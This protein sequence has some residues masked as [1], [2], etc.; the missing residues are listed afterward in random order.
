MPGA[1]DYLRP[2]R[3]AAGD[4][5]TPAAGGRHAGRDR[6]AGRDGFYGGAFGAGLIGLGRD[7]FVPDDLARPLA[8]WVEPSRPTAW[9]H[10]IWTTPPP[11]QGYLIPAAA[12][13]A[14]GLP[15]PAD[16]DGPTW[17]HLLVESARWAGYDRPDVLHEHADGRGLLAERA[18]RA[19]P[20]RPSTRSSEP[21][22]P[23]PAAG[24]GTTYLCAVDADGMGVSLINS[25]A[26]GWGAHLVVPGTG[27]FLQNRGLGF[28]L[29]PGHP[30]RVR[31][32]SPTAAHP[33][34]RPWSPIRP[35]RCGPC[36][37]PWA[38]TASRRSCCNCWPGCC[39]TGSR[40]GAA[41]A[42]PRWY[43]GDGGFDTWTT[44]DQ[45]ISLEDGAPPAWAPGLAA[46]G[47]CRS[48]RRGPGRARPRDRP[49]I[50]RSVV[51]RRRSARGGVPGRRTLS[52]PRRGSAPGAGQP[53]AG[54]AAGSVAAVRGRGVRGAAASGAGAGVAAAGG[55]EQMTF[56]CPL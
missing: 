17:P 3:L 55:G 29:E 39:A 41:V 8:R 10:R 21:R 12:W 33:G 5:V 52:G 49:A 23:G 37:A 30:G 14:D 22:P 6:R 32:R 43:L 16:P 42:A 1:D 28:S 2:G 46:A 40:A 11:S 53:P 27:I 15:L 47:S 26:A 48:S 13:I 35:A 51:R 34:A 31:T 44:D 54:G 38:A 56:C 4:P 45:V 7:L 50:G 18:A 36:S 24:G 9:G 19:A 25:N 20:G